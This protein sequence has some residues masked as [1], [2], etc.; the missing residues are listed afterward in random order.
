[1]AP[2]ILTLEEVD[3]FLG[4]TRFVHFEQ[5]GGQCGFGPLEQFLQRNGSAKNSFFGSLEIFFSIALQLE[6]IDLSP[7]IIG[8]I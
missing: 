8:Q 3:S 7:Q 4:D 1:M 2:R 5:R 6:Q